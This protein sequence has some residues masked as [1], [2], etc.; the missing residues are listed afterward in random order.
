MTTSPQDGAAAE[1]RPVETV[2]TRI[3]R[4]EPEPANAFAT[5]AAHCHGYDVYGAMLGRASW[6]EMVWLLFRGEAPEPAQARLL[7]AVAVA[8][9]NP[10]PRDPAVHAA[11]CGGVGGS[12]SASCLVAALSVGA[13]QLAGGREVLLAMQR[14]AACG[15][16]LD[17]WCAR[18]REAPARVA[19]VW[20]AP[21]HAPGFDPHSQR[22]STIAAQAL[23]CFAGI[24]P[25]PGL[26]WLAA[27]REALEHAAGCALSLTGVVAAALA[28]LGFTPEQGEMLHLILRLP[29]AAAHA[30]EQREL[31]H[32]QFPFF[33]IEHEREEAAA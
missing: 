33:T 20:P 26:R 32:R 18:L 13:G 31:G 1:P 6:A 3:W 9:A 30:L 5:R 4:E 25:A 27:Q 8:L 15:L 10:G 24:G 17:A 11:M 2:N 14:H 23:A 19:S 29:G 7:E 12:T 16:D 21:E 22:I 28:E